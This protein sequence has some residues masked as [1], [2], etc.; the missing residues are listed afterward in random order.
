M[1]QTLNLKEG[2]TVE[3]RRNQK[4]WII[5]KGIIGNSSISINNVW[6]VDGLKHNLLRINKFCNTGNE[7][8]FIKNNSIIIN[9]SEKSIVFKGRRKGNVYKTNFSELADQK[10]L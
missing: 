7:V 8:I 5:G 1:F 9:E 6:L 10:V 3:I 2:G 4:G